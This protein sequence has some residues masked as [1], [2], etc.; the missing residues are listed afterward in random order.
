MSYKLDYHYI[1]IDLDISEV[2]T[3]TV[4]NYEF[5]VECENERL[6]QEMIHFLE[7]LD[8]DITELNTWRLEDI[9]RDEFKL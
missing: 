5:T 2:A 6:R 3:I 4:F 1:N 9:L 8:V 7:Y